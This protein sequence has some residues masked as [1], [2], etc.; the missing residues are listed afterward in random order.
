MF[1]IRDKSKTPMERL[2]EVIEQDWDAIWHAITKPPQ[3]EGTSFRDFFDVHYTALPNY[4]EKEEDFMAEAYLL[5]KKFEPGGTH[6][7][8][9]SDILTW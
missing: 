1:V 4:E 9:I 7:L 5:R 2:V 6:V 8:C 3:Y